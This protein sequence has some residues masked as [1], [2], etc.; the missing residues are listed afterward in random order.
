VT[1]KDLAL[2]IAIDLGATFLFS[3]TGAMTAMLFLSACA[4]VAS[5]PRLSDANVR[6][7]AD[8]EVRRMM[9]VDPR[10]YE[11]SGPHY[12]LRGD[13]WSVVYYLKA[14]KRGAFTVRVSDKIQKASINRD[15]GGIF[16]G[17]LTEKPDYH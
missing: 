6:R 2:P 15:D 5:G 14:N 16:A 11:I 8:A 7:I 3:I 1:A 13:Y 4:T 10:Q 12:I 17:A 9:E